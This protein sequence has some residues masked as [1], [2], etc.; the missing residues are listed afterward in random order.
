M[1]KQWKQGL[2]ARQRISEERKQLRKG[3]RIAK[4]QW[5]YVQMDD[6]Q[7]LHKYDI[8]AL[9]ERRYMYL[10]EVAKRRKLHAL[11]Q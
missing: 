2:H 4:S 7:C 11:E 1:L 9:L 8:S 5:Q 10:Y 3:L 6:N